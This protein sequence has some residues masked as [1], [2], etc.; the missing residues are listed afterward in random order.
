[1]KILAVSDLHLDNAAAEALLARA[2]GVDL[3]LGAGDFASRREGLADYMR[4][5]EPIAAKSVLIPG[6][7]E[8]ESELRA[9]TSATV[10]HGESLDRGGLRIVALGAGI[11]PLPPMPWE[12]WDLT[13]AEAEAALAPFDTC[14]I[15]L[16]HSPPQGVADVIRGHGPVGSTALRRAAERMAPRLMVFGHV[17]DCWGQEGRIGATLCRNLG[18]EGAEFVL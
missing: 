18:P 5:L 16:V 2:N 7:N 13:E 15:L 14:D 4:P 12:S 1:M 8:S 10:L 6:N 3:V 17:H 9:A 11:P